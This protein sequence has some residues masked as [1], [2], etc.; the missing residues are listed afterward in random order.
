M[1]LHH[2]VT[3][4]RLRWLPSYTEHVSRVQCQILILG[5]YFQ[6]LKLHTKQTA[7]QTLIHTFAF[8]PTH[9]HWYYKAPLR[10]I[11]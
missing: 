5:N 7:V 2:K 9:T 3:T 10:G 11:C 8:P 6:I 4:P 1:Q